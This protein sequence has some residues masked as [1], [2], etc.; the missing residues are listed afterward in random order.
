M[1][2][3]NFQDLTGLEFGDLLV[4]ELAY[5]KKNKKGKTTV[6]WRCLCR[7][8]GKICVVRTGNLK[9]K[10]GRAS[11]SCGCGKIEK[12]IER[13]TTHGMS[14]TKIHSKW[15]E[16]KTRCYNPNCKDYP[17]YGG[18]GITMFEDW[19]ENFQAFYD[20]VS[21]L[22][23]YGEKNYSLD[24]IEN[25]GNYEPGNVRWAT[26]KQQSRNTRQNIKVNYKG[27]EMCLMEAAEKSGIR[28]TTLRER[29]KRGDRDDRL[30]RAKKI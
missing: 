19:K 3:H 6:Y 9:R 27:V 14:G 13:L 17:D 20:Y 18:R 29:Y 16:I 11:T 10:D 8:C 1:S 15:N 2:A 30:F 25:N 23:N 5:K 7:R 26:K 28:Y 24:R 22:E 21:M 4:L 12:T